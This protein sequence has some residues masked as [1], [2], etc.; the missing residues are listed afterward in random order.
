MK[1]RALAKEIGI[2][3]AMVLFWIALVGVL[4]GLVMELTD[5]L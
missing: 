1:D 5:W 2:A 4:V 3:A